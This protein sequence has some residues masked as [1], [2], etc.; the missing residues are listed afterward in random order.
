MASRP[1]KGITKLAKNLAREQK[2][3]LLRQGLE[4]AFEK[5]EIANMTELSIILSDII[6]KESVTDDV[7]VAVAKALTQLFKGYETWARGSKSIT[8]SAV[9]DGD[10]QG[11]TIT[12]VEG[13]DGQED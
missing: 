13:E 9:Q 5:G 10:K 3:N 7:K 12:I 11:V 8:A 1:V 2:P 4:K 6:R